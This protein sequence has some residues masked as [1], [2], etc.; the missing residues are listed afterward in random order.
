DLL[1]LAQLE[2]EQIELALARAGEC[3]KL[4]RALLEAAYPLVGC[5]QVRAYDEVLLA[6]VRVEHVELSGGEHQLA[7]LVLTVEREHPA[8]EL[9]EIADGH[10]A[11]AHVRPCPA[12]RPYAAGQ[13]ELLR[14]VG[15]QLG[16]LQ[17]GRER[18]DPFDV[19]LAGA[20]P[21]DAA[22]SA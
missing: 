22:A 18:E 21:D 15:D 11:P 19:R 3:P 6:A 1:D 20:L 13:H 5:G 16:V 9:A 14:A 17:V 7:V 4:L 8:S 2:V 12:I 10:G